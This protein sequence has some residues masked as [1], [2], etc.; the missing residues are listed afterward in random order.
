MCIR[1]STDAVATI[2]SVAAGGWKW[3]GGVVSSDGIIVGVP[4]HAEGVLKVVPETGEVTVIGGPFERSTNT[5]RRHAKYKFGGGAATPD[6]T[7]YAFP[8]DCD[9][10][11]KIVPGRDEVTQI[12]PVFNSHYNKWQ[13][14]FFCRDGCIYG[15]PCDAEAV[16]QIDTAT[17]QVRTIGGPW[18]GK[19]K[20]EGGVLGDDGA[21]YCMPQQSQSVLKIVPS[22][23]P[24]STHD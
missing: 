5:E 15:I 6:G 19:E 13:N 22:L 9:R 4:S 21:I 12:G 1:D 17:D 10:V 23:N 18:P 8:S 14:G 11:L 20:W 16:L 7:V 2:G 3:H 24:N